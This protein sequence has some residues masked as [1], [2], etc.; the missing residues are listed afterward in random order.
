MSKTFT[1]ILVPVDF[2]AYATEALLYAASIADRF[3]SSLLV[4][5]VIAREVQT[6]ATRRH[7]EHSGL[8][9]QTFSLLGPFSEMRQEFPEVT[10]TVTIDLREQART[11]LQQFLPPPLAGHA[12]ELRL[13][14]GHPFEEIL[15]IATQEHVDL[16]VMGTHGRTGLAHMTLGSVAERVVRL[17][18]CPVLTVKAAPAAPA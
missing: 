1:T 8:P 2:S 17:A 13:A 18:P 5:H 11:A 7:L 6:Y 15:A 3:S 16:I 12:L 4:F 9:H 14:V 10:D